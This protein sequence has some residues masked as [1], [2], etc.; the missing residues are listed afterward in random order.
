MT[1]SPERFDV[2]TLIDEI[3]GTMSSLVQE[4]NNTL[5]VNC[6]NVG[7]M[8]ADRIKTRQILVNLLGNAV[9]FTRNGWISVD[10]RRLTVRGTE[11]I[12]FSVADTGVGMTRPQAE[13][14]FGAFAQASVTANREGRGTGLEIASRFCKLMGGT[15]SV[16]TEPG[17][18]SNFFVHL[19]A[20]AAGDGTD[21]V[22][23]DHL[24]ESPAVSPIART[25]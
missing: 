16:E 18:G 3:V 4:R 24:V 5:T 14:L 1:N 2:E 11:T 23:G 7:M 10:V 8:L 6:D 22:A 19:P 9:K 15:I 25:A 21:F 20:E 12:Q 17:I 13:Q